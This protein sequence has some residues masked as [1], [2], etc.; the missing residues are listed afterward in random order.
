M[1]I[2]TVEE[3]QASP[4]WDKGRKIFLENLTNV[5]KPPSQ[6]SIQRFLSDNFRL[7]KAITKCQSLKNTADREY[8]KNKG[9]KFV[10]KLLTLLQTVKEI[11]DPFLQFAP[12]SI[13]IAWSA[14]GFLIQV[15]HEYYLPLS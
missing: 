9:V 15:S 6:E 10:G 7:D 12:E 14:V 5:P 2:G 8:T 1:T 3:K 11:G 4:C 13:S